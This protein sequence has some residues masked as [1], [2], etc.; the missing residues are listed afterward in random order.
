M[1]MEMIK[2]RLSVKKKHFLMKQ[3]YFASL[4]FESKTNY[5]LLISITTNAEH[6]IILDQEKKLKLIRK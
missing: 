2:L 5:S 1:E 4:S 6:D 3:W